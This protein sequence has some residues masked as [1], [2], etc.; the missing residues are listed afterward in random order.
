ML[1]TVKKKRIR[2]KEKKKKKEKKGRSAH[3]RTRRR[4]GDFSRW[5]HE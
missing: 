3:I 5:Q 4:Y 2:K 1:I